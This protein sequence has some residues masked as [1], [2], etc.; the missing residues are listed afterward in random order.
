MTFSVRIESSS[1]LSS[2]VVGPDAKRARARRRSTG[3]AAMG[4]TVSISYILNSNPLLTWVSDSYVY[5]TG[6]QRQNTETSGGRDSQLGRGAVFERPN[7]S[8]SGPQLQRCAGDS[9][10]NAIL[11]G[12]DRVDRQGRGGALGDPGRQGREAVRRDGKRG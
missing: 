3:R 6:N 7:S 11:G 8:S 9:H 12:A 4:D 1:R 2:V 10:A 5:P